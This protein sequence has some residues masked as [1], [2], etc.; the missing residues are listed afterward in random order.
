MI[1]IKANILST[2]WVQTTNV[3]PPTPTDF[4]RLITVHSLTRHV[5][6]RA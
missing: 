4:R 6:V 1:A 5:E 2:Y 3:V